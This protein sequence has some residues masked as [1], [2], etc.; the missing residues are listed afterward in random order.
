MSGG[1]LH[2]HRRHRLL[3]EMAV[4]SHEHLVDGRFAGRLCMLALVE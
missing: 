1:E 4:T 2:G 3:A